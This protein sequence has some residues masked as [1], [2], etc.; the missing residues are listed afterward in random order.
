MALAKPK[1]ADDEI[2]VCAHAFAAGPHDVVR[3]GT[4]LRGSN[5]LVRQFPAMFVPDGTPEAE[6]PS[7][8]GTVPERVDHA[9]EFTRT[10]RTRSRITIVGAVMCTM[11]FQVLSTGESV[12]RGVVL[13]PEDPLVRAHP[14]YFGPLEVPDP[15]R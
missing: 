10:T 4:R 1:I 6:W 7:E 13:H 14:E 12:A 11:G 9:P 8:W 15:V 3:R 5:P 2:F